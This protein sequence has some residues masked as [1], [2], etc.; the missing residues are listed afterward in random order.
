MARTAESIVTATGVGA[1]GVKAF[2]RSESTMR[3]FL[4]IE[5][6]V[7]PAGVEEFLCLRTKTWRVITTDRHTRTHT[8]SHRHRQTRLKAITTQH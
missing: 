4:I 8:H 5:V 3:A 6:S 2:Y 1:A 7:E